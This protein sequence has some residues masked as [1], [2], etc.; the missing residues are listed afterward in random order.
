MGDHEMRLDIR[1]ELRDEEPTVSQHGIA[2][3]QQAGD[4]ARL[5]D[6]RIGD[7][8]R[9]P[10]RYEGDG[11]RS[12]LSNEKLNLGTFLILGIARNGLTQ[13]RIPSVLISVQ[14]PQ[15]LTASVCS[16]VGCS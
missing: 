9:V 8:A 16:V 1:K 15:I 3:I 10:V 2:C 14:S 13:V 7:T 12:R 4:S 6:L 11:A 5:C